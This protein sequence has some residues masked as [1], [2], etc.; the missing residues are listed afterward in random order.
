MGFALHFAQAGGRHPDAKPLKGFAGAGVLE[1]VEERAGDAFRGVYTVRFAGA[2]YVL[3]AFQKKSKRGSDPGPRCRVTGRESSGCLGS[4]VRQVERVL[5]GPAPAILERP[6]A[7]HRNR[8]SLTAPQRT[9]RQ[10]PGPRRGAEYPLG[11][12]QGAEVI[13]RASRPSRP[14]IATSS[15]PLETSTRQA[16]T[17]LSQ[18][19]SPLMRVIHGDRCRRFHTRQRR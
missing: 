19:T 7:R 2:V 18:E 8:R 11:A 14:S 9:P 3:H 4:C 10:A 1:V 5:D 17:S 12:R 13:R 16:W 15:S 6:R